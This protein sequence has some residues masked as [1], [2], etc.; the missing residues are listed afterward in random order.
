MIMG[1]G[2]EWG[3]GVGD[4]SLMRPSK[5]LTNQNASLVDLAIR[6]SSLLSVVIVKYFPL[7]TALFDMRLAAEV[8]GE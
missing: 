3:G 1:G 5:P 2:E 7:S 6:V 4:T 8:S